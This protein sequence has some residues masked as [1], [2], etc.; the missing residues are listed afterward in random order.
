M[1]AKGI[2]VQSDS[3]NLFVVPLGNVTYPKLSPCSAKLVLGL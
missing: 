1:L 3:N 2:V